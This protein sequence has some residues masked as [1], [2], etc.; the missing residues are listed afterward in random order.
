MEVIYC[1]KCHEK[2]QSIN[3]EEALHI[4]NKALISHDVKE[5]CLSACGYG[6][7]KYFAEVDS[8]LYMA[9][10]FEELVKVMGEL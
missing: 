10:S 8:E 4:L 5:G 6:K 1:K 7:S 3:F 2:K 9:D